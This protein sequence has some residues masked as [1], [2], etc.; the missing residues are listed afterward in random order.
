[1]LD[2][3]SFDLHEYITCS[4]LMRPGVAT[5]LVETVDGLRRKYKNTH[6]SIKQQINVNLYA[7]LISI[8]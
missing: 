5:C 1:M 6:T 4:D 7:I 2:N 3:Y 8:P